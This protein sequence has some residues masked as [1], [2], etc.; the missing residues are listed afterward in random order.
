MGAA[1]RMNHAGSPSSLA[2]VGCKLS[3]MRNTSHSLTY[4]SGVSHR[5][6]TASGSGRCRA[7]QTRLFSSKRSFRMNAEQRSLNLSNLLVFF[8]EYL[9][10]IPVIRCFFQHKMQQISFSG[11][12]PP[13]HSREAYSTPLDPLVG[14]RGHLVYHIG[15]LASQSAVKM[16]LQKCPDPLDELATRTESAFQKKSHTNV[17]WKS[18]ARG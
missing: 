12:A 6:P 10:E 1:T 4:S 9:R 8:R 16:W 13:E 14:L 2:A 11:R 3:S 7:D 17:A 18:C 15:D 5:S